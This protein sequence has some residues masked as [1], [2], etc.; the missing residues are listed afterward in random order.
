MPQNASTVK[1]EKRETRKRKT[2]CQDGSSLDN[3]VNKPSSSDTPV[4]NTKIKKKDQA[5]KG[6]ETNANVNKLPTQV[7]YDDEQ[8]TF[9]ISAE[10]DDREFCEEGELSS[11]KRLK[12]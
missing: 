5:K 7:T 4:K 1:A 10:G 6:S 12:V 2:E 3:K 11:T 9:T 8:V